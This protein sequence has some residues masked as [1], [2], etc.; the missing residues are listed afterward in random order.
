MVIFLNFLLHD[1]DYSKRMP[2]IGFCVDHSDDRRVD[3]VGHRHPRD[4]LLKVVSKEP[5]DGLESTTRV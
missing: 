2:E 3:S 5:S 1:G 4:S